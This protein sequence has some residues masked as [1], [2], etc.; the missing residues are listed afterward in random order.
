MNTSGL[1]KANLANIKKEIDALGK[2]KSLNNLTE[3]FDQ[4]AVK[5][6]Y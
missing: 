2:W 6:D 4:E 1:T 5:K 3:V